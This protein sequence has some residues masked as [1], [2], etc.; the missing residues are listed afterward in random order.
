MRP[1]P[2]YRA[3]WQPAGV[4]LGGPE[5]DSS[6][7]PNRSSTARPSSRSDRTR[8]SRRTS[9]PAGGSGASSE[10]TDRPCRRPS[11]RHPRRRILSTRR[12]SATTL[13][14][15]GHTVAGR[16]AEPVL[17][18]L[19][20]LR[21]RCR[22]RSTPMSPR[23]TSIPRN[24]CG[25]PRRSSTRSAAPASP[26][27][28]TPRISATTPARC[29]RSTSPTGA[30][31]WT[32]DLAGGFLTTALA[33]AVTGARVRD[34][35]GRPDVAARTSWRSMR[36]TAPRAGTT[37]RARAALVSTVAAAD[38]RLRRVLGPLGPR[39]DA[40]DGAERWSP[41]SIGRCS[42]RAPPAFAPD[43]VV[44]ADA[45]VSVY[46][47]DPDTGER[48]WDFAINEPVTRSP[49][50]V[51]G[52]TVLVATSAGRLTAIDLESGI[53]VWQGEEGRGPHAEPR[54][55][56]ATRRGRARRARS[57]TRR[58]LA[59]PRRRARLARSRPRT[60]DPGSSSASSSPPAVPL[61]V[62][63]SGRALAQAAHGPGVPDAT[64][65]STTS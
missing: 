23:S 25:T 59:R 9:R 1:Q 43:A 15:L 5:R 31:R 46:R 53:L 38:P 45:L 42:S 34:R 18:A 41:G 30:V 47:L 19:V 44:V 58:L 29:T 11:P 37:R 13:P 35:P 36:P 51:A 10:T 52:G 7:S 60:P 33:V 8:S 21:L 50:V 64:R 65:M 39:V 24:R 62:P 20:R 40:S 6:G 61:A 63:C 57:R 56:P 55:H 17:V 48:L 22:A 3:A 28:E 26:S 27:T 4:P 16:L 49:V 14:T 2:P 32:A 12:G 54:A